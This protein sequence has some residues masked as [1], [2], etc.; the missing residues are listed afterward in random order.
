LRDVA[1]EVLIGGIMEHIEEAGVHSGDS[2]CAIPP[3]TLSSAAV[4]TIEE[5]TRRLADALDVRGLLNVQYAVKD[6]AVMVIE[7]N[8]RASRTVPFVSKA[9]GVPLAKVASRIM[10]GATIAE[11]REEGLVR[12][13]AEGGH[14]S[15]KEAV[16]PFNRFPDVD[17]VLGPEMRSTGEVMGIDRSFGLAF[18]KSQAAAGNR[19]PETGTIFLSLADRDKGNGLAAAR[20]FADLGFRII[21]TTGTAKACE[22]EGIPIE[23]VV[24][25][26]GQEEGMDAVTLISSG[27][28]DLVVNT[29]RGRGPRADGD[30]IRRAATAHKVPCLTTAAAALAAAAGIAES[31]SRET[32]VRALQEYHADGQM[33]LEV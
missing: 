8:P 22:E 32:T 20:R 28:V 25:K 10:V 3:P 29:P 27:Q 11:L 2:A 30:H 16:L 12:P 21:A 9:T 4:A 15:V 13:P 7:A 26:M 1:G 5:Y 19:L 23:A 24:A 6:G 31:T 33:R 14:V 18:A 17:T